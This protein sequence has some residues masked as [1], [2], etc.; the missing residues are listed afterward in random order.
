MTNVYALHWHQ[1]NADHATA[2][3]ARTSKFAMTTKVIL[4]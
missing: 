4:R 3:T 1:V 2:D